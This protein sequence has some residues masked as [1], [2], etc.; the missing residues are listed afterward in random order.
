M[1]ED[2]PP[3]RWLVGGAEHRR[4]AWR[5]WVRDSV[6]GVI[7]LGIHYG[8]MWLPI[9]FVCAFGAMCGAFA[10]YRY[11]ASDRRARI[12]WARLR[13][14]EVD[15]TDAAVR[16]L[17]RNAGRAL[18]EMSVLH[19][20]W[21]AGRIEV[22]GREIMDAARAT[23]RPLIFLA[24]HLGNWETLGASLVAMG[25]PGAAIYMPP[26]NRFDHFIANQT[27]SRF[28]GE[29]I[30]PGPYAGRQAIGYL[31]K[32]KQILLMYVD[33]LARGRVWAP[34]F[35]RPLRAGGNR[36]NNGA[37]HVTGAVRERETTLEQLLR[38]LDQM[39]EPRKRA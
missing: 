22:A 33:E 37:G 1:A 19:R 16:R 23:G 35:G 14:N 4:Q 15:Q 12:L 28:G 32:K 38:D 13:P 21:N 2:A 17:W 29:Y 25:Y 27:R 30:K 6:V 34:A 7:N 18:V 11:P 20:L 39:L 26:E 9:D 3:L 36:Y 8:L 5:Y 31:T 10:K 24:F